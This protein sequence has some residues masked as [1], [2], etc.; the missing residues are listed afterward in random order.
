[1]IVADTTVFVDYLRGQPDAVRTVRT[2]LL[3][4]DPLAASV[5]TRMELLAGVRDAERPA[6]EAFL[7]QI[8]WIP[9]TT[10][11]ADVAGAL[12]QR[13]LRSHGAISPNDYLIGATALVYGAALW[14]A[15]RRHFPYL[16]DLP[17]PY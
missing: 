2:S 8:P 15:N 4:G 6:L 12:M 5:V 16:P 3:D 9:V 11:I 14:T 17:E 10:D 1:M 7:D 13:F